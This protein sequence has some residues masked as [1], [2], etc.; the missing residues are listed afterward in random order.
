MDITPYDRLTKSWPTL[1]RDEQVYPMYS[2]WWL[3]CIWLNGTAPVSKQHTQEVIGQFDYSFKWYNDHTLQQSNETQQLLI[4][5]ITHDTF[6][7]LQSA[8]LL[9]VLT[10]LNLL[11][12]HNLQLGRDAMALTLH[13][14]GRGTSFTQ[15][16]SGYCQPMGKVRGGEH[17]PTLPTLLLPPLGVCCW[18]SLQLHAACI[19]ANGLYCVS[20]GAAS[21]DCV[22]QPAV[23]RIQFWATGTVLVPNLVVYCTMLSISFCE[24]ISVFL[25]TPLLF[26]KDCVNIASS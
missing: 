26:A 3:N 19:A 14:E 8:H 6:W 4:I 22:S 20:S 21:S 23:P 7:H 11:A 16:S 17:L 2:L 18:C 15:L 12:L 24:L 25:F 13:G 1:I 9:S 5:Y 10:P